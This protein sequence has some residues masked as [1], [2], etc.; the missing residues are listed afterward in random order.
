MAG[1]DASA[2]GGEV[3]WGSAADRADGGMETSGAGRP[4]AQR[5]VW[6]R[7]IVEMSPTLDYDA[8]LNKSVEDLTIEKLATEA[9]IETVDV[10]RRRENKPPNYLLVLHRT[11][12]LVGRGNV[13][14]LTLQYLH[15]LELCDDLLGS[16]PLLRLPL[17]ILQ[18]IFSQFASFRKCQSSHHRFTANP[19][20]RHS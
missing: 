7:R 13:P 10:S 2:A 16:R 19:F 18:S 20:F 8:C 15:L 5:S 14:V 4:V 1:L 12:L 6:P 17:S 11:S 9:G 3:G